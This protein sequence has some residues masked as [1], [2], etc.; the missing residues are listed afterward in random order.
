MI[1]RY[2]Y[3]CHRPQQSGFT[4][5]HSTTDAILAQRLLSELHHEFKQLLN[6]AY[7]NIKVPPF[8]VNPIEDFHHG[9]TSQVH[10]RLTSGVRQGS[11]LAP[12]ILCIAIDWIFSRCVNSMG[13]T[14][15]MSHLTDQ[16]YANDAALFT[17]NKNK[18][19]P[20]LANFDDAAR[21]MGSHSSWTKTKLQNIGG[22][23]P[24]SPVLIQCNT[25]ESTD[26]FIYLG[27]QIHSS[28]RSST[29]IFR[30]IGIASSVMGRLT[31]VWRQ[32]RLSISTKMR[33]YYALVKSVLLY[34][35]E[36]WTML[37]RM[38]I[39]LRLSIGPVN[40]VFLDTLV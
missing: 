4:A 25:V 15:G 31:N 38:S 20:I 30:R 17:D 23:S 19:P 27:C 10:V 3:L 5:S 18:W 12:A 36:T 13:T 16:D 40:V 37:N 34:G 1:G 32:S 26:C 2:E 35:V 9:T 14:V 33:L 11:I 8:L 39:N 6:V 29:K 22:G 24:P 7:I 28:G 21:T